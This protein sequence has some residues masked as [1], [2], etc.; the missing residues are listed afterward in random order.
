MGGGEGRE[1]KKWERKAA[2]NLTRSSERMKG[3]GH[4][5]RG[6]V[7]WEE[8]V[9][10]MIGRGLKNGTE[11]RCHKGAAPYTGMLL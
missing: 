7:Q 1:R 4:N 9:E 3:A 11:G 8:K 6:V 5:R 2:E 10:E